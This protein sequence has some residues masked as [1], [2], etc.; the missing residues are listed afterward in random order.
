MF[1][2]GYYAIKEINMPLFWKNAFSLNK[3][4]I[5]KNQG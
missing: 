3:T 2:L 1:R 5:A 4:F